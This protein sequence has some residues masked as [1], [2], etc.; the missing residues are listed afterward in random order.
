MSVLGRR[1]SAAAAGAVG[2]LSLAV[3][4]QASTT[5]VAKTPLASI[6]TNGR[7]YGITTYGTTAYLVGS[8]TRVRPAGAAPGTAQVVRNHA[9]AVSLTTGKLLPWH[10]GTNGAV[11]AVVVNA[12]G[13]YMAGDFTTESGSPAIRLVEVNRSTGARVTSFKGRA[14]NEVDALALSGSGTL[15]AGGLFTFVD[16]SNRS[17]IAALSATTG[18][19]VRGWSAAT[20]G[21]VQALAMTADHL[22][23]IVGGSFATVDGSSQASIAAL[24]PA[25]GRLVSWAASY[26]MAVRSLVTDGSGVYAGVGGAGGTLEAFNPSSGNIMW[27][28]GTDGDVQAL[29]LMGGVLYA[30]GHF[31]VFCGPGVGAQS[32]P[33]AVP[34]LK[35]FAVTESNGALLGWHP[36]PNSVLGVFAMHAGDSTIT[37]GGDFTKVAGRAQQGF[38]MFR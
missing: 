4:A 33:N 23:L 16:H 30:G 21:W 22:K 26:P 29:A 17:H 2:L 18:G 20:D 36:D 5:T 25:S 38:A 12:S 7:V 28:D 32:C 13:V 15:Y 31:T 3:L 34:R 35:L 9:A 24:N 6:Q 10:A 27:T 37:A 14:N 8:F 11:H 19:L 1:A